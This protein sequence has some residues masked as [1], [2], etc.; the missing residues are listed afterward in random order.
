MKRAALSVLLALGAAAAAPA[1]E[2][3]AAP[4]PAASAAQVEARRAEALARAVALG[5]RLHER[6][7][8]ALCPL[9]RRGLPAFKSDA[10]GNFS[11]ELAAQVDLAAYRSFV[12]ALSAELRRIALEVE[13]VRLVRESAGYRFETPDREFDAAQFVVLDDFRDI[14]RTIGARVYTFDIATAAAVRA[15]FRPPRGDRKSQTLL[16]LQFRNEEGP[17]LSLRQPF[18]L[19]SGPE[20]LAPFVEARIRYQ[21]FGSGAKAAKFPV[22][23]FKSRKPFRVPLKEEDARSLRGMTKLWTACTTG[24]GADAAERDAAGTAAFYRDAR[25]RPVRPLRAEAPVR[26]ETDAE[27]AAAAAAA[28]AAEESRRRAAEAR[29]LRVKAEEATAGA[30]RAS[31]AAFFESVRSGARGKAA[32]AAV[33]AFSPEDLS[34]ACVEAVLERPGAPEMRISGEAYLASQLWAKWRMRARTGPDGAIVPGEPVW[35]LAPSFQPPEYVRGAA[36]ANPF[37]ALSLEDSGT[38]PFPEPAPASPVSA[39]PVLLALAA[40][41]LLAGTVVLAWFERRRR[42]AEESGP[43]DSAS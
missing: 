27:T 11:L 7:V 23:S 6:V 16:L 19:S 20:C 9:D 22:L 30:V 34:T 35:T 12:A 36:R 38:E 14:P 25:G 31:C 4:A 8:C 32:A 18:A 26:A 15:A 42:L 2:P 28:A 13:P 40:V 43:G 39:G 1:Q 5:S 17:I 24:A 37:P 33:E 3:A 41:A 29:A 10:R 21:R